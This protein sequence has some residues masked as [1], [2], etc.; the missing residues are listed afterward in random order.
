MK[1]KSKPTQPKGE[2]FVA[3]ED[4]LDLANFVCVKRSGRE[5][6]AM[7]LT[8]GERKQFVFGFAL[9]GIHENQ[10]DIHAINAIRSGYKEIFPNEKL[11]IQSRSFNHDLLRQKQLKELADNCLNPKLRF[12][13][14]GEKYRTEE[15]TSLGIRKLKQQ[16]IFCTYT[17]NPVTAQTTDRLEALLA[18]GESFW[19]K[20]FSGTAEELDE[21][22]LIKL[23]NNAFDVCSQ[24]Q[25]LLTTKMRLKVVPM[26]GEQMWRYLRYQFNGQEHECTPL[27]HYIVCDGQRIWTEHYREKL[28]VNSGC[29]VDVQSGHELHMTSCLLKQK[30]PEPHRDYLYLPER[31]CYV[32]IMTFDEPPDGWSD[33]IAQFSWLWNEIIAQEEV[34]DVEI[35]TQIGWVDSRSNLGALQKYTRQNLGISTNAKK[36]GNVDVSANLEAIEAEDAQIDLIRGNA[37]VYVGLAITIYAKSLE[38][39]DS[40]ILFLTSRF[41]KPAVLWRE[42]EYTWRVWLQT[43]P[44]RWEGL[45]HKKYDRRLKMQ[46]RAATGFSQLLTTRS[47]SKRGVEFIAER[48]GA[49]I[50]VDFDDPFGNPRHV[51]IFG[52]TG[53][54]KSCMSSAFINYALMCGMAVT[55]L[56]FPKPNSTFTPLVK[57]LG[58]AEFDTG[59]HSNNLLELPDLRLVPS[60]VREERLGTFYKNAINTVTSLVLDNRTYAENLPVSEIESIITL[61]TTSFYAAP[62]IQAAFSNARITGIGTTVWQ[63]SPT[64]KHLLNFFDK[65]RLGLLDSGTEFDHAINYCKLRLR[66]WINSP[67]GKAISEPSSANTDNQL[68]LFV[69]R[70]VGEGEAAI[71]GLSGYNAAMRRSLATPRSLFYCDEA[72]VLLKFTGLALSIGM[73]AATGRSNGMSLMLATQD[74]DTIA[75]CAAAEQILQNIPVRIIGRILN[76]AIDSYERIFKYPY[77]IIT[78]NATESFVPS[79]EGLFSRWLV[80]DDG[81]LTPCRFYPPYPLLGITVN[82]TN[83][84]AVR[85]KFFEQYLDEIQAL[86]LYSEYLANCKRSGMQLR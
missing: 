4:E 70:D 20:R 59:K 28:N 49:P 62:E 33:D 65:E 14:F 35:T 37:S 42:R 29:K 75:K 74:P 9:E 43:L 30:I 83:E 38:A 82:N 80:D 84:I 69:A 51:A 27:P 3:L 53:S 73:F 21:L 72:S 46:V 66:H 7:L 5:M 45:Y 25:Q 32:G 78:G 8:Q 16:F 67:F 47:R 10:I 55:L 58:G 17:D 63:D 81:L 19:H 68:I 2:T 79:L 61:A 15:L 31:E 86:G 57:F 60:E 85:D 6:W 12:F 77:Q 76:T 11:T 56:D 22:E 13:I 52:R 71:L 18:L 40:T 34:V 54:G 1:F 44:I 23:L 64:L 24:R 48:G 36:K 39:L 50:H 41:H 26:D